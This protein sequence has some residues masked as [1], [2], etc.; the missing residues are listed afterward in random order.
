MITAAE[1]KTLQKHY[2]CEFFMSKTFAMK[3]PAGATKNQKMLLSWKKTQQ[4][5]NDTTVQFTTG[6]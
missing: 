5:Q 2:T 6:N 4:N 3:W 1:I